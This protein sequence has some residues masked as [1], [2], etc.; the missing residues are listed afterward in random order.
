MELCLENTP[1]GNVDGDHWLN[2]EENGSEQITGL[3]EVDH[4]LREESVVGEAE[5]NATWTVE[6]ISMAVAH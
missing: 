4:R 2:V 1:L 5:F 6:G 3:T